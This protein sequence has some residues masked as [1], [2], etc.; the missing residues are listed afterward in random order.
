MSSEITGV[1][2][3]EQ[4]YMVLKQRVTSFHDIKS[5]HFSRLSVMKE[6]TVLLPG[7]V[8]LKGLVLDENAL[9][10]RGEAST[11]SDLISILE[12][13]EMFKD[14]EF[15]APITRTRNNKDKFTIRMQLEE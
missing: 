12:S 15:S 10:I 2:E 1:K 14:V 8:W 6:L 13:S 9:E 7:N 4:K 5:A 3:I 11:A